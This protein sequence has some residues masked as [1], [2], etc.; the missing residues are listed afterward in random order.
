MIM[1]TSKMTYIYDKIVSRLT[2]CSSGL[3]WAPRCRWT[4]FPTGWKQQPVP[5]P[6][7]IQSLCC[8]HCRPAC[9]APAPRDVHT[10]SAPRLRSCTL[11]A[12]TRCRCDREPCTG[13]H[14]RLAGTD[15]A[16]CMEDS[17][18]TITLLAATT[19]SKIQRRKWFHFELS[20]FW[21]EFGH[22]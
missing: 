9:I 8:R 13:D 12:D 19:V 11:S 1:F 21:S 7:C 5:L 6:C 2:S 10:H 22:R 15:T 3:S 18:P 16:D 20:L 14:S 17:L 4:V